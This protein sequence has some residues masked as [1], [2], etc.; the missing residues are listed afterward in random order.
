M[1][2]KYANSKDIFFEGLQYR[3]Y[4]RGIMRYFKEN[5]ATNC[6]PKAILIKENAAELLVVVT[7]FSVR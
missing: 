2:E 4:L 7:E 1:K 6:K 3:N 5:M